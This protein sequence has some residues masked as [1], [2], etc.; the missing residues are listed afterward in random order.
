M[1]LPIAPDPGAALTLAPALLRGLDGRIVFWGQGAESLYG[2]PA[3][4]AIGADAHALLAT[5]FSV[6][7]ARIE[8]ILQDA[9]V[10]RGEIRQ[11]TRDGRHLDIAAHWAL[12]RDGAGAP[13]A[14][15]ELGADIT[16]HRLAAAELARLTAMIEACEDAIVARDCDGRVISWNRAAERMSGYSAAEMLGR[17]VDPV[18]PAELATDEARL[19]A[20]VHGGERIERYETTRLRRDGTRVPLSVSL[21]PIYGNDGRVIGSVSIARDISSRLSGQKALR[22]TRAEL[23]HLSRL[24]ELGQIAS[25]LAHEINQPLT[26]IGNYVSGA[27]RLLAAGNTAAALTALERVSEQAERGAQI[28]QRLRDFM[29][30]RAIEMRAEDLPGVIDEACTLALIGVRDRPVRLIRRLDPT[31]RVAVLD[32]VQIEQVLFNLMRNAIEAMAGAPV[33]ELTVATCPTDDGKVAVSVAD[34]GPGLPE[35][36]RRRLFQ[37]FVTTKPNGLGVGLSICRAIVQAHGGELSTEDRSGGGTVFRFT[38][39]A[40]PAPPAQEGAD[41]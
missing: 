27:R 33:Q 24:S 36:V 13:S 40:P 6:P 16:A 26:A 19:L 35:E 38:L 32:R 18:V 10:W 20:R 29:R 22:E 12:L 9:G 30:K 3:A 28:V 17:P 7:R 21:A 1:S 15:L 23:V 31:A 2:W 39:D 11:R 25:A 4:A 37:P 5:E 34:T 14:V 41:R 8:A